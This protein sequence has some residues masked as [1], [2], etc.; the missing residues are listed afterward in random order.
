M[1][2]QAT[3]KEIKKDGKDICIC[4]EYGEFIVPAPFELQ[5]WREDEPL[6]LKE[7]GMFKRPLIIHSQSFLFHPLT[8][9]MWRGVVF[10][11]YMS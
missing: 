9:G 1:E 11:Q 2:A 5:K 8:Q 6:I 3:L 7:L 4:S 10:S